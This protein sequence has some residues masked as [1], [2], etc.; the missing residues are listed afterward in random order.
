MHSDEYNYGLVDVVLSCV[1]LVLCPAQGVAMATE[2]NKPLVLVQGSIRLN[3]LGD[4]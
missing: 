4:R 3:L 1:K 2:S